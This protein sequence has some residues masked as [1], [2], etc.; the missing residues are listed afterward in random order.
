MSTQILASFASID[1]VIHMK[2]T[3]THTPLMTAPYSQSN[4]YEMSLSFSPHSPSDVGEIGRETRYFITR[5]LLKRKTGNNDVQS[6]CYIG[7]SPC[8]V[9]A[10]GRQSIPLDYTLESSKQSLVINHIE[11]HIKFIANVEY[12][13]SLNSPHSGTIVRISN[14]RNRTES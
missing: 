7:T 11:G 2:F 5:K 3:N 13:K 1:A 4:K 6:K 12:S 10:N 8:F 14:C 9:G